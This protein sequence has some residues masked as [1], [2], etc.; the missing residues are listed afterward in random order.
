MDHRSPSQSGYLQRPSEAVV[1]EF[2][3]LRETGDLRLRVRVVEDPTTGRRF[4]DIRE[5]INSERF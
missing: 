3:P 4:L 2:P 1:R 5:H